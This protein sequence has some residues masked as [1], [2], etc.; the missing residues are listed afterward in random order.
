MLTRLSVSLRSLVGTVV[1]F[2]VP[3][4]SHT[5]GT[6]EQREFRW[7]GVTW[8]RWAVSPEEAKR[9][10]EGDV[11]MMRTLMKPRRR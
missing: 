11:E 5:F 6:P 10:R 2:L 9:T 8:K 3:G 4:T 1:E 7:L